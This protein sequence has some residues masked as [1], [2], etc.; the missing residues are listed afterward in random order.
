MQRTT[1][2]FSWIFVFSYFYFVAIQVVLAAWP[3]LSIFHYVNLTFLLY[4]L[5]Y[6][7][8]YINIYWWQVLAAF[9]NVFHLLQPLRALP[10][11]SV[12]R[13]CS[14]HQLY[15]CISVMDLPLC[16]I[17]AWCLKSSYMES[18]LCDY[19]LLKVFTFN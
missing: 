7:H 5:Q 8:Q 9:A 6:N 1:S 3:N 14:T 12:H 17:Y 16:I 10:C 2:Y 13:F 18:S 15:L 11:W 19:A 4:H